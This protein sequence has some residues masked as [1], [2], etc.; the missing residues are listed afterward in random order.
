MNEIL[1]GDAQPRPLIYTRLPTQAS[2]TE[3][4]YDGEARVINGRIESYKPNWLMELMASRGFSY[5]PE[6]EAEPS[7]AEQETVQT[8][9]QEP[10]TDN[11]PKRPKRSKSEVNNG[12]K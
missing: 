12:S 9:G 5:E 8:S 11:K 1:Q 7:V 2:W 3:Y 4:F 10:A 6:V